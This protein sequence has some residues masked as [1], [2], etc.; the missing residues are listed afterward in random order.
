MF[1]AL[2]VLVFLLPTISLAHPGRGSERNPSPWD[3][4]WVLADRVCSSGYAPMDNF[5]LGRDH[6]EL[7][8]DRQLFQ[9]YLRINGCEQWVEGHFSKD[10]RA[11]SFFVRRWSSSCSANIPQRFD[12]TYEVSQNS[13]S[14]FMGPFQGPGSCGHGEYL[15]SVF[16]PDD[17]DRDLEAPPV[18][19]PME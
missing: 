15:E 3:G 1:K 8:F 4:R 5:V 17:S 9:S 18:Q 14:F 6:Y 12:Y 16:I 19:R 2:L 13:L 10:S 7:R 11:I